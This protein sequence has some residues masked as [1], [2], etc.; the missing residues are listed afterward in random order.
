MQELKFIADRMLGKLAK[1][2][3]IMG[4]DTLYDP[5]IEEKDL[6]NL[7]EK[8]GRVVLTRNQKFG[9]KRYRAS[10]IF[11]ENNDPGLQAKEVISRL[12][13]TISR[14]TLLK[15]CLKCNHK[16]KAMLR[17]KAA[18][19]VPEYIFRVHQEFFLCPQCRKI[20]WAGT[21]HEN[22]A[23]EITRYLGEEMIG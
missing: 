4:F 19:E 14:S 15:R 16:L 13:L 22:M 23:R 17:E 20:F 5:R 6:M 12:N 3:R 7:A 18:D 21:H 9:R 1:W 11:V 2:L 8:E 10:L